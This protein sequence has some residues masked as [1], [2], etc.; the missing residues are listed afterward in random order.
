MQALTGT[1]EAVQEAADM[2]WRNILSDIASDHNGTVI[3]TPNADDSPE[4]FSG[5]SPEIVE[6]SFGELSDT[7]KNKLVIFGNNNKTGAREYSKGWTIKYADPEQRADNNSLYWIPKPENYMDGVMNI[8]GI[9][10]A[11]YDQS[12]QDEYDGL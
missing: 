7:E 9:S 3:V 4:D 12:W 6:G 10:E 8:Q 2:I 5:P 1:Q 11:A